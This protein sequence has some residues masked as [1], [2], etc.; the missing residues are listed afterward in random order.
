MEGLVPEKSRLETREKL[1]TRE[2]YGDGVANG[3]F[4]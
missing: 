3:K 4:E 2:K 1:T